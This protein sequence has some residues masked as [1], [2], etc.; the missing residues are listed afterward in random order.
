MLDI[1]ESQVK[2]GDSPVT[3]IADGGNATKKQRMSKAAAGGNKRVSFGIQ[4]TATYEKGTE[5]RTT[6]S[7]EGDAAA[8][9]LLAAA[10]G[11]VYAAANQA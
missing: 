5:F 2:S 6:P 9:A 1:K 3:E 4:Q 10:T 8:A 11:A 7:P